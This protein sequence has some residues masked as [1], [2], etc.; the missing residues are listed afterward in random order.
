M[1]PAIG[2]VTPES[3]EAPTVGAARGFKDQT[4]V[5]VNDSGRASVARQGPQAIDVGERWAT[6]RAQAGLAG[7]TLAVDGRHLVARRWGQTRILANMD[8]AEAFFRR[9]GVLS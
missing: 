4:T 9:I 2:P 5:D 7:W 1:R 3:D 6:L 8:A